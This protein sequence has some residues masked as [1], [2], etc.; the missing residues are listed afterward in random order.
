MTKLDIPA[1]R[2]IAEAANNREHHFNANM[3]SQDFNLQRESQ[4]THANLNRIF[5]FQKAFSPQTA[6]SLLSEVEHLR[7]AE[8]VLGRW[9]EKK[10]GEIDALFLERERL[11]RENEAMRECLRVI[12]ENDQAYGQP[13]RLARECLDKDTT[14]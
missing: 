5:D 3:E 14:K 1:L 8:A 4:V 6:L 11:S 7:D 9:N 10:Q 12:A 13:F 2:K